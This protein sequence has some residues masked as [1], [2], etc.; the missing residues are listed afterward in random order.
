MNLPMSAALLLPR[1]VQAAATAVAAEA[2]SSGPSLWSLLVTWLLSG[3]IVA[4][5]VSWF[6]A[7]RKSL[8]DERA[9]V[10]AVCA[11]AFEVVAA[12]KEFPYAITRRRREDV[13]AAERIKLSD[14]IRHVQTRLSYY[15][16]WMKGESD[17][18]GSAFDELVTTAR[19]VAGKAC[20]A[21]WLT[22]P[23]SSRAAMNIAPEMIDLSQITPFEQAY[24]KAVK[25]HLDGLIKTR[26]IFSRR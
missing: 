17:S 22:E 19:R 2:T 16:T 14:E 6:L 18:L 21:A 5:L 4:A 13:D 9:R 26:R 20:H 3:A 23:D 8:E 10:R 1:L 12:Y 25:S 7:R 15:S 11:E 24:I